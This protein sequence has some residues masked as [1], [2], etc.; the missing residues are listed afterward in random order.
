MIEKEKLDQLKKQL[1][2]NWTKTL[3][4]RTGKS[5]SLI[6]KVLNGKKQNTRIIEEAIKLRDEELKHINKIKNKL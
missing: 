1:P 5:T 4:L 6:S 3:H 2:K